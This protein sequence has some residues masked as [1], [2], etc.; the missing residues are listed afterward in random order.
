MDRRRRGLHAELPGPRL[1]CPG[2]RRQRGHAGE[3]QREEDA[4]PRRPAPDDRFRQPHHVLAA[5]LRRGRPP[6][7][8]MG[9]PAADECPEP[10]FGAEREDPGFAPLGRSRAAAP[11]C[12]SRAGGNQ[13]A[14]PYTKA[15]QGDNSGQSRRA[16]THCGK[17][18]HRRL[19][20][21]H[22][23]R[24]A[25]ICERSEAISSGTAHPDR[26]CFVALLLAMTDAFDPAFRHGHFRAIFQRAI[27][28][29]STAG[30]ADDQPRRDQRAVFRPHRHGSAPDRDDSR[31]G[32]RRDG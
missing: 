7:E 2:D 19:P 27:D 1:G 22:K 13:S 6:R 26:D 10:L 5:P 3:R 31:R 24:L 32:A 12:P 23:C 30:A 28:F 25:V 18:S 15:R 16:P 14:G 9:C 21:A 4:A 20:G 29:P 11:F 8:G 17:P